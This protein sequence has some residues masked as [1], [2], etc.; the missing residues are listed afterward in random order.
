V[1]GAGTAASCTEAA[2]SAA[3]TK[4]GIITFS[5]GGAATMTLSATLEVPTDRD[6]VVDGGNKVTLDGGGKVRIFDWNHAN[7][8]VNDHSLTLQHL[9]ISNGKASGTSSYPAHPA[10]CSS[11]FYDGAGG[12]VNMRDGVLHVIDVS[13]V[14]NQAASVGPDVGGGAIYLS[15]CKEAVVVSST[16]K[17]NTGSNGGAIGA[18]NSEL[19]VSN[20]TFEGNAAL[21]FGANGDDATK[22]SFV[23]PVTKQNQTGSGGNGGA[24][25][26]DGGSD[27]THVFC[28]VAFKGN[29]GGVGALGGAIFRTPDGSKRTTTIDRSLFDANTGDS[30]G[31][32]YFHN[33]T[34][35]ITASTFSNNIGQGVG[36]IQ[37]DGSTFGFTNVTFY[38]NHSA[39]SVGATLA[40]FGGDGTLTNC[41]FADNVC[42]A[43]NMFAAAIFGSPK[44]TINNTLFA[45]NT[46]KNAG[47]PMQCQV[48]A[49]T[50]GSGDFQ[51]P[52]VK[53]S[54]GA[55]D[56][57][58]VSGIPFA[59]PLLG[60]LGDH[61]GPVPTVLPATGSPALGAG[62]SCPPTDARGNPRPASGCTA[63]AVEGS[64]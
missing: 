7:Y 50:S 19:S 1:V 63:G 49:A 13:F 8:R 53:A 57:A 14:Q 44:L 61:G 58:C 56:A 33:S 64:S 39:T 32:C 60:T 48:D 35:T 27:G 37:A 47:A 59:D 9:V 5:C 45:N 41:T 40:L 30:G 18:L 43:A 12:A 4:G 62:Q 25:C 3:I 10:P 26:I 31:A 20:S 23:D 17:D 24:V 16:F 6:T 34:L 22:C 15:G 29:K 42:D 51:W 28:G 11:G 52:K 36:A 54:G 2:L 55:T 21:G 46:A 38:G